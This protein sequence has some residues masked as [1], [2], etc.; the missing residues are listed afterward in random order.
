MCMCVLFYLYN[1]VCLSHIYPED[2][3]N[4]PKLVDY[5]FYFAAKMAFSLVYTSTEGNFLEIFSVQFQRFSIQSKKISFNLK[6]WVIQ[7]KNDF[8]ISGFNP[9]Q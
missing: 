8:S 2:G 1:Q 3:F 4:K 6:K 7:F 9:F 5:D